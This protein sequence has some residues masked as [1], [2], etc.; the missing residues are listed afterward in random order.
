MERGQRDCDLVVIRDTRGEVLEKQPRSGRRPNH[1]MV[2]GPPS[3]TEYLV[4]QSGDEREGHQP[5]DRHPD[6]GALTDE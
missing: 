1:G 6:D 3:P 4:R 2:G 5:S